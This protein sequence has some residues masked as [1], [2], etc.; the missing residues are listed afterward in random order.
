MPRLYH[1]AL[2]AQPQR[3]QTHASTTLRLIF[4]AGGASDTIAAS[5][6]SSRSLAKADTRNRTSRLRSC[7]DGPRFKEENRPQA[8]PPIAKQD[9]A[10]WS[11]IGVDGGWNGARPFP[12]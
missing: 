11:R 8:F 9:Q 1:R 10:D 6:L 5:V 7:R 2:T 12:S 3:A 4:A